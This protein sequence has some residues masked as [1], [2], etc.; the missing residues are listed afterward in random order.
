MDEAT[1]AEVAELFSTLADASRVRIVAALASEEL[2][3]G[4]LAERVELTH[5][6]A[7]HHLRQLRQ[8]RLVRARKDGRYVYYH[9]DDDH[10]E[11]LFRCGLEHARHG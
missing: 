11:D 7:S 5:S 1:A 6:A 8:M 10:V 9:L 3:V 2:N 4:E